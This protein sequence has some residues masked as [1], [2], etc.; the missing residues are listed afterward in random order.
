MLKK[1][2]VYKDEQFT[3]IT[4]SPASMKI[5]LDGFEYT[6]TIITES[7]TVKY[8]IDGD[9]KTMIYSSLIDARDRVCISLIRHKRAREDMME[10]VRGLDDYDA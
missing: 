6:I 4:D 10:F 5:Q 2:F 9:S 3:I 1:S 8:S 7:G